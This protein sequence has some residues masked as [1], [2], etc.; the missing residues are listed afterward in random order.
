MC[1]QELCGGTIG[2]GGSPQG[3]RVLPT[4]CVRW[5]AMRTAECDAGRYNN[6]G[7]AYE[8]Y[9]RLQPPAQK[10][11]SLPPKNATH[12]PVC[13]LVWIPDKLPRSN[14]EGTNRLQCR[15]GQ[16]KYYNQISSCRHGCFHAVSMFFIGSTAEDKDALVL[17]SLSSRPSP[18]Y[19][20]CIFRIPLL[21]FM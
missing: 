15:Q 19:C 4:S 16:Q 13:R 9:Q 18:K 8:Q 17:S 12:S 3:V 14:S 7:R 2:S 6:S 1:P 21:R 5:A 20:A 10:L 11:E